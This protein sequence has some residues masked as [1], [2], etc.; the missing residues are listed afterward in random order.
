MPQTYTA[1][2]N[3]STIGRVADS[4]I[5]ENLMGGGVAGI[6]DPGFS[7]VITWDLCRDHRSQL[8]LKNHIQFRRG[9]RSTRQ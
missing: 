2:A 9:M 1:L 3:P 8:Q 4:H 5:S 6:D 7:K